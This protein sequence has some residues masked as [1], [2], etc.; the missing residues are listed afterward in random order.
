MTNQKRT[1]YLTQFLPDTASDLLSDFITDGVTCYRDAYSI[2]HIKAGNL[3]DAFF[4]QGFFTAQ[5]RLFQMDMDRRK[6]YGRT[7]ELIGQSGLVTDRMMRKFQIAESVKGDYEALN[8]ETKTMLTA[9]AAG[10]NAFIKSTTAPA[11]E[12]ALLDAA[13]E[14]WSP[15][16]SLAV[17]KVRHLFMGV[18]ESKLWRAKLVN[19]LGAEE[20]QK[21]MPTYPN[22]GLLIV[23]PGHTYTGEWVSEFDDI[24][25]VA[26]HMK[27]LEDVKGGSNNW[28]VSGSRTKSGLPLLAGDPHR[29]LDTP[30]VYYQNQLACPEFDV[31][32]FSFPGIPGFPHFAHNQ[33]A[34][35]AITHASND[36]QDLYV[37]KLDPD[38]PGKYL[39]Q[40]QWFD[41][42]V[43]QE[44][45]LVKGGPA[46]AIT[47][48]KTLHGPVLKYD[49]KSGSALAFKY[50]SLE[51][52]NHTFDCFLPMMKAKTCDDLEEAVRL[53]VDP[54]NNMVFAD[55]NGDIGYINRG[56]VPVRSTVANYWVPV[57]GW[58]GEYEWQGY[59]PFETLAR[60]RNPETG[61]V[62]TANNRITDKDYPYTLGLFYAPE[63][64]ARRIF[65]RL[66]ALWDC[67]V[68]DME[69][70]HAER[71]SIPAR[72]LIEQLCDYDPAHEFHK[73]LLSRLLNWNCRMDADRIEPT[74][75]SAVRKALNKLVLTPLYG[76]LAQKVFVSLK[77]AEQRHL[78]QLSTQLI[79]DMASGD[80]RLLPQGRGWKDVLQQAFSAG[81]ETLQE[82]F[83][84]DVEAWQWGKVHF[85]SPVHP[86]A[87]LFPELADS[88]NPPR[89]SMSGDGDTPQ[90]A[91]FGPGIPFVIDSTSVARYV[92][93]L[94][95]WDMSRWIV[96]LGSSGHA[97]SGHYADQSALWSQ[98]EAIEMVYSWDKVMKQAVVV[99]AVTPINNK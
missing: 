39:H 46:E 97:G 20:A 82:A 69:A 65:S 36:Y 92:F 55:K 13:T 35:W 40:G 54:S 3:K 9:Y 28:V 41:V 66:S 58:T 72:I 87:G 23:P 94:A 86:L 1:I 48:M 27:W 14:E 22:G 51:K 60:S 79:L 57:S 89:V 29:A 78:G 71:E 11:V 61:F 43:K 16:D 85:T 64:R 73:D 74:L 4:G 7:S 42:E 45:I 76:P 84:E 90:S 2:P 70:I 52:H 99:Q 50:T 38:Q 32:G 21:I 88:L 8:D 96:P 56:Q 91:H 17:Y 83:G 12:Y 47:L 95:D 80:T 49:P 98:V 59:V 44:T 10:V 67:T 33:D 26:D 6:A 77:A 30:N 34:A 31:I 53:W 18:F 5:D 37:E 93:D 15:Y 63:F 24:Q 19:L 68:G 75:Y 62:V 25:A 81:V